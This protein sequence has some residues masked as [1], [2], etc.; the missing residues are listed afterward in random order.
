M[1]PDEIP[2]VEGEA[3][4]LKRA[5]TRAQMRELDR[6]AIEERRIPA[7]VL[8]ENAGRAVADV[9][10]ER[11]SPACPVI[12]VCGRGSNGGDGFVAA[13]L[14]ADRGFEVE[15]LPL[16]DGY[17]PATPAGRAA[18]K[19]YEHEGVE[20]VGRLKKRAMGCVI[21][22]IFGTGLSREVAGAERELIREINALNRDWFPVIAVDIPSGLD[23]DSGLP[24]GVAIKAS[25]TVTMGWPKAGFQRPGSRAW[26]GELIVADIGFPK[27]F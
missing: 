5:V 9:V 25:A 24:L 10:S 3:A 2:G 21:D 12:A 22:A 8:M 13:R 16:E 26:L 17:D 7:D 6:R 19:A 1:V 15:V 27:D 18:K 20:F 11:V 4:P 14:L 23:A